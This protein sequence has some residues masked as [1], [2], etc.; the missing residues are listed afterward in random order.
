MLCR[1]H[2]VQ[3]LVNTD[4]VTYTTASWTVYIN[5]VPVANLTQGNLP[6]GVYRPFSYIAASD[7][8]DVPA[9]MVVDAF[10]IYDY[11]LTSS[12]VQ[13]LAGVYQLNGT[14]V[15]PPTNG[16]VSYNFPLSAEDTATLALV[17]IPP[18]FRAS[19]PVSP[20]TAVGAA[21]TAALNYQWL[22]SD[23]QDSPAQAALHQGVIRIN[24]ASSSYIDLNTAV[25]PNSAGLI[26]PTI[27]GAG[28]YAY[29]QPLQGWTFETV[30]KFNQTAT[31]GTWPKLWFLGNGAGVD[32]IVMSWNG[33][34]I[35]GLGAQIYSN[36]AQFPLYQYGFVEFLKPTLGQWS[37]HSFTQHLHSLQALLHSL[38]L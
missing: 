37:V 16:N 7:W 3:S 26:L 2:V 12:Q 22:Q 24:G 28:Q 15:A 34:D 19:F 17:P 29:G 8:G 27:G 20:A 5:G 9:A 1:Y 36:P 21:T 4:P 35:N 10:R 31:A 32:D 25:G 11:A 23:P 38:S 13:A 14:I 33:N 18:V 6:L 30:V